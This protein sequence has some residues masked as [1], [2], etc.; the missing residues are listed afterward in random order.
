MGEKISPRS[1]RDFAMKPQ[2][3]CHEIQGFTCF[4]MFVTMK[5]TDSE[6]RGMQGLSMFPYFWDTM[7]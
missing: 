3:V 2:I 4:Y 1:V 5:V 6:Y 7:R